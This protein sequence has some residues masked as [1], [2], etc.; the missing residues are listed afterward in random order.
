MDFLLVKKPTITLKPHFFEQMLQY[1]DILR[2]KYGFTLS[3][4]WQSPYFNLED[5]VLANTYLN[6]LQ[7]GRKSPR[8]SAAPEK[9]EQKKG[10][11]QW[12]KKIK[13]ILPNGAL[14]HTE[15]IKC[16]G[17][18]KPYPSD[19]MSESQAMR[20]ADMAP[21]DET[22]SVNTQKRAFKVILKS[23]SAK[24]FDDKGFESAAT[25]D[26]PGTP[27]LSV[28]GTKT[29]TSELTSV[30]SVQNMP[31]RPATTGIDSDQKFIRRNGS[32]AK[33]IGVKESDVVVRPFKVKDRLDNSVSRPATD[34]EQDRSLKAG[35]V[36]KNELDKIKDQLNIHYG[37][38]K[39]ISA[40]IAS[41]SGKSLG[42]TPLVTSGFG[43]MQERKPLNQLIS[44]EDASSTKDVLKGAKKAPVKSSY[45]MGL[46][47]PDPTKVARQDTKRNMFNIN[48]HGSG[49]LSRTNRRGVQSAD[50]QPDEKKNLGQS[51]HSTIRTI[52][53]TLDQRQTALSTSSQQ[54]PAKAKLRPSNR[55]LPDSVKTKNE[56]GDMSSTFMIS[57]K[58]NPGKLGKFV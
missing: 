10:N 39:S 5:E 17:S 18:N 42:E 26:T 7:K 52:I 19:L 11:I 47:T 54:Q 41:K 12:N 28:S 38:A 16:I 14:Q 6:T 48:S 51:A 3:K 8:A 43:G 20:F 23:K 4:D 1:E 9:H 34:S 29:T 36:I 50:K 37:N 40:K 33:E 21:E 24:N 58:K 53:S 31:Q 46:S 22:K 45:K 25:F 35:K 49:S 44:G 15:I 32:L 55:F 2:K 57:G 27:N 13:V 56:S 30:Y